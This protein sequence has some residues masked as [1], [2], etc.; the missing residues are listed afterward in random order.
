[1]MEHSKTTE[2]H[3]IGSNGTDMIEVVWRRSWRT[4]GS[5]EDWPPCLDI[6]V[7]AKLLFEAL[8]C[9]V[10][11]GSTLYKEGSYEIPTL[12]P[13]A[14]RGVVELYLPM[15]IEMFASKRGQNEHLHS[16]NC[17]H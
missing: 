16:I 11:V 9:Y 4:G 10:A 17:T 3:D 1:M 7:A 8:W 2:H 12:P 5:L 13:R 15:F 14:P 6:F